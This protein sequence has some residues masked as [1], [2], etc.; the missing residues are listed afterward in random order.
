MARLGAAVVLAGG[1]LGLWRSDDAGRSWRREP[2]PGEV[3]EEGPFV[4]GSTALLLVAPASTSGLPVADSPFLTL[5][6]S[7]DG[8]RS[9]SR[10]ATIPG[11]APGRASGSALFE[12]LFVLAPGRIAVVYRTGDCSLPQVLRV[13]TD[14]GR[15]WRSIALGSL[16]LPTALGLAG[17]SRLVLASAFC[18][19]AAPRYGQGIFLHGLAGGGSWTA[20]TLPAGLLDLGSTGATRFPAS[21]SVTTFSADALAF[22]DATTG[23]AVGSETATVTDGSGLVPATSANSGG[24]LILESTDGG[25]RWSEVPAPGGAPLAML[26]CADATH[27]LAGGPGTDEL[28]RLSGFAADPLRGGT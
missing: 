2:L 8:G 1:S 15:R 5:L 7:R 25:F 9:W 28:V 13:S 10:F 26:S 18:G 19:S 23:V 16:V 17:G 3:V 6:A 14:S 11:H 24:Q 27:C 22:P 20:A 21:S 4:S 12:S